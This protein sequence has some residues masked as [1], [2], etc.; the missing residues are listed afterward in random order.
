MKELKIDINH[1][2][3]QEVIEGKLSLFVVME[4]KRE[5]YKNS[6]WNVI[7]L[8]KFLKEDLISYEEAIQ[9]QELS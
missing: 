5:Q 2:M 3:I 4:V 8:I 1:Q 7:K 9:I 6:D